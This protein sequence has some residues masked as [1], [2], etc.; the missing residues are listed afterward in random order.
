[1]DSIVLTSKMLHDIRN[2]LNTILGYSQIFQ[3]E[4]DLC[5]DQK[6][7]AISME[8]A[9]S[10]IAT[11]LSSKKE[12]IAKDVAQKS[13]QPKEIRKE[14]LGSKIVIIDDREENLSLISEIL[15]PY[16]YDIRVALNGEEGLKIIENFHPELILLDVIMPQIDG[17]EV[18]REL[19]QNKLTQDIPVIFLTAKD[20]TEDVVKGFEAGVT[21]YI[22][23]PFHPKE[24]IA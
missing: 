1:M 24:L 6:K 17:Y 19:K 16:N 2:S 8:R 20:T 5:E 14:S 13:S 21:D 4:E 18:L 11:L 23:K 22:A 3:D 15:S 9:A 10:K 12:E 7:M